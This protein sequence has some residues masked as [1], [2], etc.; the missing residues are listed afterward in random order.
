MSR[1]TKASLQRFRESAN[2]TREMAEP[3]LGISKSTLKRIEDVGNPQQ[4]T[5]GDLDRMEKLYKVPCLWYRYM[6]TNDDA[7]RD[8]LPELP[9][10]N[11]QGAVI[12]YF[13]EAKDAALLETEALRDAADGKIDNPKT[14]ARLK[15]EVS[16]VAASAL[17]LLTLLEGES[18]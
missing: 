7:F 13:V 15:K 14:L 16:D 18:T 3:L 8:H 6:W 9:D 2:I 11:T 10:Y 17:L 12:S 4:P 5:S 1:I